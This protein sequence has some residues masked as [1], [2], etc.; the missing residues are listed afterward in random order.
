MKR[1]RVI[2]ICRGLA[3]I[4][5]VLG[6]CGFPFTHELYTFHVPI[7]FVISGYLY[8]LKVDSL[9][10][11]GGR[12]FQKFKRLYIPF[13]LFSS[14][15]VITLNP[16]IKFFLYPTE[17]IINQYP[18]IAHTSIY[19]TLDTNDLIYSLL[20]V[21]AFSGGTNLSGAMWF[22]RVLFFAL[23]IFELEHYL[24]KRCRALIHL[25][26]VC[27][28]VFFIIGYWLCKHNISLPLGLDVVATVMI[29][30]S[31]GEEVRQMLRN[32][33]TE[34]LNLIVLIG[35]CII[36]CG[37]VFL[38]SKYEDVNIGVNQFNSPVVLLISTLCGFIFVYSLSL[39][40]LRSKCSRIFELVG[41]HTIAI[42]GWHFLA[43]KVVNVFVAYL[44]GLPVQYIS[45]FPTIAGAC[46]IYYAAA[47]IILPLFIVSIYSFVRNK[48]ELCQKSH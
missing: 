40:I 30:L 15:F 20:K 38:C 12:I 7:F 14:L 32:Q 4:A 16:S 23:L 41:K 8:F 25:V 39:L 29:F 33:N 1:D 47:G 24:F 35:A 10:E 26:T 6:H 37:T 18:D 2:D 5:V 45:S 34:K 19:Q 13:V 3:M 46:W 17:D 11:L 28:V 22:L 9:K 21:F 42:L 43:F 48:T 31:L 44:K 27:N 36:S